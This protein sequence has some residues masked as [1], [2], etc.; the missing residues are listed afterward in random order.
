MLLYQPPENGH[1]VGVMDVKLRKV[2]D[3]PDFVDSFVVV[4]VLGCWTAG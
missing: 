2:Q 3:T 4:V 1:S